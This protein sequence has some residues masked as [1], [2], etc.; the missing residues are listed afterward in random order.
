MNEA[1]SPFVRRSDL[2]GIATLTL[3]RP[4]RLNALSTG[5]LE[6]LRAEVAALRDDA[7]TRV[8]VLAGAGR[9]FCAGHDLAEMRAD[10]SPEFRANLFDACREVMTALV[11][12]PQPV[13][14]RVQG[15]AVAAGCQLVATCDLA[16][17]AD[18]AT[19]ALPGVRAGI[20]CTTP[21]VAVARNLPRKR[22]FELLVTGDS[23]DATTAERWGLVNRVVPAAELDAEVE[24]LARRIAS[25]SAAVVSLGKRLFYRQ[26]DEPLA[27]AYATA[28]EGMVCNMGLEDAA[29]GIDAFLARRPPAWRGRSL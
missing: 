16:V 21:G 22:T 6:A 1:P 3:D 28:S 2:D 10:P 4:D 5:M 29:E 15:A 14:A 24:R 12:L 9:H 19:F 25:H 13:I 8:V 23:I 26:V 17:A 20:F 11:A 18:V 27:E 7:S